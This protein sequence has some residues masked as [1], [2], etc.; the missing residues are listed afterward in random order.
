[1]ADM[2]QDRLQN[3]DVLANAIRDR[4]ENDPDFRRAASAMEDDLDYLAAALRKDPATWKVN[5]AFHSVHVPSLL[6]IMTMLNDIDAMTS[7]TADERHQVHQSIH[8][9]RQLVAAARQKIERG[10]FNAAKVELEVLAEYAPPPDQPMKKASFMERTL[11]GLKSVSESSLKT[12]SSGVA[13]VPEI[14]GKVKV[15]ATSSLDQMSAVPTLAW[16]LKK[17]LSGAVSDRVTKPI[18]MRL[19]AGGKALTY[20]VGTGVGIGMATAILFPP[21]L[22]ISAG[23]AVLAAMQGWRSEM[24]SARALNEAERETRI[25]ELQAERSAALRKLTNGASA[26]QMESE[27]LSLTVDVET[28]KA[29]AVILKGEHEGRNWSELNEE[30]QGQVVRLSS[31]GAEAL[32]K[33]LLFGVD[34]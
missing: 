22:P 16:N 27:D 1:M 5:R 10:A 21:L 12:A 14:V 29:D 26:L 17:T 7:V 25:A 4:S 20:G 19:Q 11:D 32:V 28:G 23:G 6:A 9:A 30:E 8:R 24:K 18:E 3:L 34:V 33:I 2:D 15:G 13:A 31:V